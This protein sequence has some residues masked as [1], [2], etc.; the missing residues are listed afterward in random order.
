MMTLKLASLASLAILTTGLTLAATAPEAAAVPARPRSDQRASLVELLGAHELVLDRRS[1]DT[2]GP[3]VAQLL[4]DVAGGPNERPTVRVRAVAALA[5]YPNASTHAYLRAQLFERTWF[6]S[7]LGSKMR[8]QALRSLG[9]A[10]GDSAI[11]DIASL[12]DDADPLV[13][14]GVAWALLD[15]RSTRGVPV[16]EAWLSHEEDFTVRSAVD[17]ALTKLRGM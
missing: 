16:L 12:R 3:D 4:I 14:E 9:R 2:I 17:Q 11:D 1:L 15:T 7:S 8:S 10:Y 5:L 13:R 6:G